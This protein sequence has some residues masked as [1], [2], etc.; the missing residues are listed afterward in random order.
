MEFK[1]GREVWEHGMD[2]E[3]IEAGR[4]DSLDLQEVRKG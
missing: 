3:R 1:P 4:R 2:Q